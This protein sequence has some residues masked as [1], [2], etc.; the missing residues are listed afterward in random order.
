M[1][2]LGAISQV[3]EYQSLPSWQDT[4]APEY[5]SVDNENSSLTPEPDAAIEV[6]LSKFPCREDLN[7]KVSLWYVDYVVIMQNFKD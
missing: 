1:D 2:P 7:K 3:I 4:T 5:P 6:S